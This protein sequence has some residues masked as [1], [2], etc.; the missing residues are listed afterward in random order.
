MTMLEVG[1]KV[2][3]LAA[4]LAVVYVLNGIRKSLGSAHALSPEAVSE[5]VAE[6]MN[7][8]LDELFGIEAMLARAEQIRQS[9][10]TIAGDSSISTDMQ[11]TTI[12]LSQAAY[13]SMVKQASEAMVRTRDLLSQFEERHARYGGYSTEMDRCHALLATQQAA[14]DSLVEAQQQLADLEDGL[15]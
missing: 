10:L 12:G 4:A 3:L 14:L 13:V 8:K 6:A 9:T 1:L 7:V 11:R 15:G 2:A 5:Q